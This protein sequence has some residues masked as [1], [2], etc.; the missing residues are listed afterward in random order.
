[1][2]I[3]I[4][5]VR[6]SGFRGLQNIEINLP[7]VAVLLGVNNSGKTSVIKALQ[8]AL[9]DYSRYLSDEDFYIGENEKRQESVII[10]LRIIATEGD[11]RINEFSEMWQREFGDKIQAEPDGKQFVGIRTIAKSDKVKGGFL[12]ERFHLDSWPSQKD[13]LET[14]TKIKN[15]IVRRFDSIPFMPI[16][17]QRDIHNEL[18]EKS[19]FVGRVLSS[20]EYDGGV[21]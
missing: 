15:K 2:N 1:M 13:W 12:V 10:D 11:I 5:T 6:I 19:S 17:A 3:Q 4:D 20:I 18:K 8:L 21:Q 7:R 9:G 16:D 14:R